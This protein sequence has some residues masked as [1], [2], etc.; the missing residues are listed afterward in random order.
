MEKTR[1]KEKVAKAKFKRSF[2]KIFDKVYL[3]KKLLQTTDD[4]LIYS[5]F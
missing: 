5:I 1:C 4:I 2:Q 3:K